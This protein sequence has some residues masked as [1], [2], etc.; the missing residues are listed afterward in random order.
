MNRAEIREK[1]RAAATSL[2]FEKG[3]VSPVDLYIRME[4]I[5]PQ[6]Y[7]DWR[8]GRITY[9]EKVTARGLGKLNTIIEEL[10][11]YAR[12]QGWYPSKTDY[13]KWGKGAKKRL[14]FTKSGRPS[15]EEL[16]ATHYL[17][18]QG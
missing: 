15:L 11:T 12:S 16:Y 18:R 14:R 1:T 7:Q 5:S 13:N 9:L 17:K 10:R 2:I 6:D 3:Y 4:V 8:M